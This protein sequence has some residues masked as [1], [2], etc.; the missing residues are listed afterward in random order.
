MIPNFDVMVKVFALF[1]FNKPLL[2]TYFLLL[3]LEKLTKLKICEIY[4]IFYT[5][6][7]YYIVY[8]CYHSDAEYVIHELMRDK[9]QVAFSTPNRLSKTMT[10]VNS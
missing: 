2:F 5:E 9:V 7:V 3:N 4:L 6:I 10:F 1:S 8:F